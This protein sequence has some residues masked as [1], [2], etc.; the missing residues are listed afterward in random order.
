MESKKLVHRSKV[1]IRWGDMDALGHVN[2]TVYF[3]YMEQARVAW[4]ESLNNPLGGAQGP[5]LVNAQ[6][7][8]LRQLKYPGDVEVSCYMGVIGRSSFEMTYEIRR[9][10]VP[11]VIFAE[12]SAK[13]VWIDFKMEKSVPLP[14]H[15]RA[16]LA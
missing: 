7:S 5:V 12:G 16:L 9:V 8:F 14:D 6:C 13:L 3:R 4:M 15:V 1:A 10:D 11:E 2:N